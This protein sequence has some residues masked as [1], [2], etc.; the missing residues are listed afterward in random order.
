MAQSNLQSN[1]IQQDYFRKN[2]WTIGRNVTDKKTYR[3]ITIEVH[4][5]EDI[6]QFFRN[7]E[8]LTYFMKG[9]QSIR[10][11]TPVRSH[12]IMQLKSGAQVE[13]DTDIIEEIPGVMISWRSLPEATV[14]STGSVWL[15]KAPRGRGTIV[16]LT[17]DYDLPGG[18]IA[19]LA[20]L[21][22]GDD[23]DNLALT[24]LYRM[25][26]YLETGEVPTTEGQSSGR[27]SINFDKMTTRH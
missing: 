26:A 1:F 20:T 14:T 24:N 15:S 9:I 6:Y 8:N 3:S 18:K 10:V 17:M 7:F 2:Y 19:D 25:K 23:L 27:E 21:F 22:T 16:N 12:W 5:P 11:D 4:R 13:W